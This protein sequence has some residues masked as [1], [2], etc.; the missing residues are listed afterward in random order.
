MQDE[1]MKNDSF[2]NAI[3]VINTFCKEKVTRKVLLRNLARGA[4]SNE[5]KRLRLIYREQVIN[6]LQEEM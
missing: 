2:E 3:T 1:I 5:I 6:G 4:S